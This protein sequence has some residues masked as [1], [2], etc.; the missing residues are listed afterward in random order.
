MVQL[1]SHTALHCPNTQKPK[2]RD[3]TRNWKFRPVTTPELEV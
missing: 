3:G 1:F 2:T